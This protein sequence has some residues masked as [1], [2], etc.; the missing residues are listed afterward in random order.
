[1]TGQARAKALPPLADAKPGTV[2]NWLVRPGRLGGLYPRQ[3]GTMNRRDWLRIVGGPHVWP[4][5]WGLGLFERYGWVTRR[6][7]GFGHHRPGYPWPRRFGRHHAA[8]VA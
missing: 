1:M 8:F 3:A 4:E 6:P 2:L 7:A 5:G